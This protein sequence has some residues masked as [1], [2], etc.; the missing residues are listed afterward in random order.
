MK[1]T[2]ALYKELEYRLLRVNFQAIYPG[3][4]MFPFALYDD[5]IV[6]IKRCGSVIELPWDKRFLGNTSIEYDGERI[7]IW[8]IGS[9]PCNDMDRLAANMVHEMFHAYQFEFGETRFPDDIAALS[10]PADALNLTV[11]LCENRL[12][13]QALSTPHDKT[14]LS[15]TVMYR[16][17]RENLIGHDML[18]YEKAIETTEGM[19]EYSGLEALASLAPEKYEKTIQSYIDKLINPQELLLDTRRLSYFSG[20]IFFIALKRAGIPFVSPNVTIPVFDLVK[21][22]FSVPVDNS[23]PEVD[24]DIKSIVSDHLEAKNKRIAEFLNTPRT[25]LEG[26]FLITGYDP[27]NMFKTDK[28]IFCSHFIF[29][30]DKNTSERSFIPGPVLLKVKENDNRH[31]CAY[32][33]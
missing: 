25:V 28:G 11:K 6:L 30:T 4:H 22:E 13:A 16:D 3:F 32:S 19:A 17:Y 15:R 27:M 12:I 33:V 18:Y 29:L 9:D 20:A 14:L 10:Y 31:I 2:S 1:P 21:N 7:A 24:T 23:I 8:N 26:D 5:S